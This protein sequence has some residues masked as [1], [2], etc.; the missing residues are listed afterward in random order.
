MKIRHAQLHRNGARAAPIL[1]QPAVRTL[2]RASD[3]CIDLGS[4]LQIL[5]VGVLSRNL[6]RNCARRHLTVINAAGQLPQLQ[7]HHAAD[8]NLYF[9]ARHRR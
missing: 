9:L 4:G 3:G 2:R 8:G 5:R 7:P 6:L 1:K